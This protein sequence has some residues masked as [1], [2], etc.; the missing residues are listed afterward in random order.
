MKVD[1]NKVIKTEP[2]M[3]RE[4]GIPKTK[5]LS[6]MFQ[7]FMFGFILCYLIGKILGKY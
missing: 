7:G 1:P 2:R 6:P 5:S 4:G 3:I